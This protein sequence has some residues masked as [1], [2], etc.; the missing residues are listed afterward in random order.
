MLLYCLCV[1]LCPYIQVPSSRVVLPLTKSEVT[2][3]LPYCSVFYVFQLFGV[4]VVEQRKWI[5]LVTMRLRVR[6][7][8]SLSGLRIW[9]G[10]KKQKKK[11]KK[12]KINLPSKGIRVTY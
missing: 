4:P 12:K 8:A 3:V 10:P 2:G 11:K 6:S 1:S 9:H 7:L 5:Q